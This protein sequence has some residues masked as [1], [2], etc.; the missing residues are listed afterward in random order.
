[1]THARVGRLTAVL[2]V[3]VGTLAVITAGVR[4]TTPPDIQA[5]RAVIIPASTTEALSLIHI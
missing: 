2:I 5:T 4:T 1:M 3:L